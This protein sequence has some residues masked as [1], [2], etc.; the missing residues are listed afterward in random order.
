MTLREDLEQMLE[1]YQT[2][3]VP[4]PTIA[5]RNILDRNPEK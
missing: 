5:I 1:R 3:G 4:I 2:L